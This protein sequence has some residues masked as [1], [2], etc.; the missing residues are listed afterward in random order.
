MTGKH[1]ERSVSKPRTCDSVLYKSVKRLSLAD[2][3]THA[4]KLERYPYQPPSSLSLYSSVYLS[5]TLSIYLHRYIHVCPNH[6]HKRKRSSS[7]T[8]IALFVL[9]QMTNNANVVTTPSDELTMH[10]TPMHIRICIGTIGPHP[11]H[12]SPISLSCLVGV[13]GQTRVVPTHS[14]QPF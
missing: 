9:Q 5:V 12:R 7:I 10:G 3:S 8:D 6:D 4:R 2:S 14:H 1:G 13:S 11:L